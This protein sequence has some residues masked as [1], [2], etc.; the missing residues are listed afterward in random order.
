M[1]KTIKTITEFM[2][3]DG[4]LSASVL[5]DHGKS[6]IYFYKDCQLI[7]TESYPENDTM[8]HE[9]VAENYVLGIKKI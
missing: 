5:V 1:K 9:E 2:S 8:Y 6:F 4:S 7:S 3:D